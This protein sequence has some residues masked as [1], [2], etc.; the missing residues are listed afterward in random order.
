MVKVIAVIGPTS[1]GKS[2]LAIKLAKHLNTEIISTDSRLVYRGMDIGTA[3]PTKEELSEV[4]HYLIDIIDPDQTYSVA[5]YKDAAYELIDKI[6]NKN[7]S[8]I[9][10]GG[11][12]QYLWSLIE[13]WQIPRIIPDT[14]Y[15]S[16]LQKR[17][18]NGEASELYEELRQIDSDRASKID[19]R[20]TRRVIRALELARHTHEDITKKQ[21]P[22]EF[23]II[24]LNIDRI[25]LYERIDQR[26]DMM[27]EQGLEDEVKELLKKYDKNLPSMS[28]IGYK[29]MI[30]YLTGEVTQQE[31]IYS[32]KTNT[33][34][35]ARMQYNWFKLEDNR[36]HWYDINKEGYLESILNQVESFL[37]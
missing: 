34:R 13:N 31:A 35:L 4:K 30:Q 24:G 36:I 25:H 2:S 12:G 17:A 14:E 20:N 5:E 8:V 29:Q 26:V 7:G 37:K 23:L 15:R 3:K 32:I 28:G 22:F 11:T 9:L 21:P 1:I 16:Q 10:C 18:E 6:G 19:P 33:H 27:I